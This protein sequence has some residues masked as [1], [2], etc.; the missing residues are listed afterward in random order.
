V[1]TLVKMRTGSA[2]PADNALLTLSAIR[3]AVAADLDRERSG[4]RPEITAPGT[5]VSYT[6]GDLR[7][8]ARLQG[9]GPVRLLGGRLR[10]GRR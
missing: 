3:A 6:L 7:T 5:Y 10:R 9:T 4:D 1:I 2:D 8:I